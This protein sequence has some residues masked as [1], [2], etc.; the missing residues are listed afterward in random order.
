MISGLRPDWPIANKVQGFSSHRNGGISVAPYTSLNLGTHVN[1]L[2]PVVLTNRDRLAEYLD[3]PAQP[4]WLQ[5]VHGN[6]VLK[7]SANGCVD[8]PEADAAYTS[9][10]NVVLAIMTADCLPLL[11]ASADGL[12]IAAVHCGWRSIADNIIARTL[13]EFSVPPN[14]IHAWLGPAIG[15]NAFEVWEDVRTAML[16]LN[17]DL[18]IAFKPKHGKYFADIYKIASK[19]LNSHGVNSIFGG[20]ECTFTQSDNYFSYRRDGTTGR[21]AT[22]IWR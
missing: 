5:Q 6:H 10:E 14:E 7:V 3:L 21:M 17:A 4:C 13:Q 11:L 15:P 20:G 22:L 1:D 18:D 12:E 8:T 9:A 16:T 19:E 2:A